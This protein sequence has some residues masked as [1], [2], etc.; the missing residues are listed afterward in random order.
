MGEVITAYAGVS[1]TFAVP[2]AF[3]SSTA[4][5]GFPASNV[6]DYTHPFRP[7]RST[8]ISDDT[9]FVTLDFGTGQ[10]L[11]AV[12]IDNINVTK[13]HV[14]HSIDNASWNSDYNDL[15]V[16]RC[17]T[18]G[19]YKIYVDLST[20][21]FNWRYLRIRTAIGTTTDGTSYLSIGSI[22]GLAQ[23]NNWTAVPGFP[24]SITPMRAWLPGDDFIAGGR[25][26]I[27]IGNPY[28]QVT[29]SFPV[30]PT[31][32]VTYLKNLLVQP[33]A[34]PLVFYVNQGDTSEVYI[35]R[36]TADADLRMEGPA[37]WSVPSVVL[38]EVV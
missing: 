9:T 4:A 36:R 10:P 1:G 25:E 37:H 12:V 26:P 24:Y 29:L 35:C 19:R 7:Y 14:D 3:A 15:T 6:G 13:I 20:K 5:T 8:S 21:S 2:S 18:S 38:E 11:Y 34:S 17:I 32:S 22:L 23:L 33:K 30:I 27:T 28:A 16:S 31:A